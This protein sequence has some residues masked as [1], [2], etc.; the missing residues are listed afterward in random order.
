MDLDIFEK[1]KATGDRALLRKLVADNIPLVYRIACKVLRRK[2]SPVEFDNDLRAVGVFALA[3]ALQTYD[4]SKAKFSTYAALWIQHEIQV[5]Q[6]DAP[7]VRFPRTYGMPP[8]FRKAAAE[9]QAAKAGDRTPLTA[10]ELGVTQELL[11]KWNREPPALTMS[12][13]ATVSIVES[14]GFSDDVVSLHDVVAD[15]GPNQGETLEEEDM[16]AVVAQAMDVLSDRQ[17]AILVGVFFEGQSYAQVAKAV[18]LHKANVRLE[19]IE[20]IDALRRELRRFRVEGLP[21]SRRGPPS[22]LQKYLADPVSNLRAKN[23]R[24]SGAARP[25]RMAR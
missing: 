24:L 16:R 17:R 4:P 2:V 25:V 23:V 7:V 12:L 8:R 20:A 1:W 13:D 5:W 14:G 10:E 19:A 11:D 3:R 15:T 21:S 22:S 18:G 6:G 9:I